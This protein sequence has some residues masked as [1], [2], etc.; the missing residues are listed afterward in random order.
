MKCNAVCGTDRRR[1]CRQRS[2]MKEI[3]NLLWRRGAATTDGCCYFQ[4]KW[5]RS[6]CEREKVQDCIAIAFPKYGEIAQDVMGGNRVGLM[7]MMMIMCGLMH[8]PVEITFLLVSRS[9]TRTLVRA[10]RD[11]N[12]PSVIAISHSYIF[13]QEVF[14]RRMDR[15]V[16]CVGSSNSLTWHV[17]RAWIEKIPKKGILFNLPDTATPVCL[18]VSLRLLNLPVSC[19]SIWFDCNALVKPYVAFYLNMTLTQF[20]K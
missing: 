9:P 3:R 8:W 20:V 12:F 18:S 4:N 7:P 13:T 5:R 16:R 19:L 15:S 14:P 6:E 11:N 1:P 2:S 17:T 10:W